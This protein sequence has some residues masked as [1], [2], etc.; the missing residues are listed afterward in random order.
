M[1][2]TYEQLAD[3]FSVVLGIGNWTAYNSTE[4]EKNATKL[5]CPKDEELGAFVQAVNSS[6]HGLPDD[7]KTI[8]VEVVR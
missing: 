2:S 4:K 8:F 6:Y 3:S 5:E 1:R 7:F